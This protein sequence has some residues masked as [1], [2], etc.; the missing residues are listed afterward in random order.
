MPEK[1]FFQWW[2]DDRI[3]SGQWSEHDR[4]PE[5]LTKFRHIMRAHF[6]TQWSAT[7]C[8]RLSI[9]NIR[10]QCRRSYESGIQGVSMFGENSPFNT[11]DEFNYLAFQYFADSPLATVDN[12][13]K[14]VMAPRL[15]GY[16]L[17]EMYLNTAIVPDD[18]R[19][20]PPVVSQ[21]AKVIADQ[22]DYEVIRRWQ[23]LA[24]YLNKIYWEWKAAQEGNS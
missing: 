11:N 7:G 21:I 2:C 6:G 1:T 17:G 14:D 15:G 22:K 13:I 10:M 9:N 5:S 16:E 18:P 24:H 3:Y 20:I 12:F 8:H 4:I 19:Y 23:W